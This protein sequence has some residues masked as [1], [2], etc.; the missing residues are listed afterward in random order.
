MAAELDRLQLVDRPRLDLQIDPVFPVSAAALGLDFDPVVAA[1]LEVAAQAVE[2]LKQQ[3]LVEAL[4]VE[5]GEQ[6]LL[7][8]LL[9]PRSLDLDPKAGADLD[10]VDQ[11]HLAALR[12][13]AHLRGVDLGQAVS[14]GDEP[15]LQVLGVGPHRALP[16]SLTTLGLE[17]GGQVLLGEGRDRAFEADRAHPRRRSALHPVGH[18]RLA[19][20]L[21]LHPDPHRGVEVAALLEHVL[22][23]E[24]PAHHPVFQQ[25]LAFP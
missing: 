18:H 20:P 11:R 25:R 24:D 12:V 4:R 3:R 17:A 16:E 2:R 13:I 21:D 14:G 22:E 15:G 9:D 10:R 1:L 19:I 23:P 5:E 8:Q 7:S 6:V